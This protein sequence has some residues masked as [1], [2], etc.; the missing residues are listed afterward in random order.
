MTKNVQKGPLS[1]SIDPAEIKAVLQPKLETALRRYQG[2]RLYH[3]AVAVDAY[4][5]AVPGIPLVAS[6]K[7]ALI[8]SV[9]VWDDKKQAKVMD[10]K[11][12]TVMEAISG[13][14]FFGSGLTQNKEQ[15]LASLT[16]S[17]VKLVEKWLRKNEALFKSDPADTPVVT[18][19]ET[20][21]VTPVVKAVPKT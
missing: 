7:S 21:V 4:I 1:R 11:Q 19:P 2:T 14:S 3:V 6:P 16:T 17:A 20:P 9:D 13:K 12:I 10:R 15:Q 8:I 18:P 5:L